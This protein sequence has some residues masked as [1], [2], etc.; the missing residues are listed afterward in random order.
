[1]K[2]K[3]IRFTAHWCQPCKNLGPVWDKLIPD[4]PDV[5]FVVIDI[6]KEPELASQYNIGAIP[7]ILFVRDN[8]IVGSLVGLHKESSIRDAIEKLTKVV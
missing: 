3:A 5:E 7:T 4:F 2:L 8:A 6:D 1:M